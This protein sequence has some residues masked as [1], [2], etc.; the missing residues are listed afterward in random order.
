MVYAHRTPLMNRLQHFSFLSSIGLFCLGGT[1]MAEI[2]FIRDVKPV[3]EFNCVACHR[4]DKAK[5]KLRLDEKAFA[6]KSKDVLTPGD[7]EESALYWM[8]TLPPDD[9]EIMP[10]IEHEDK[11]YPLLKH[12]Q[13]ILK[14]WIKEG[15]K[16]PDGVKLGVHK[17]LP[18]EITFEEHVQPII[19]Q[20]CV[21]CHRKDKAKGKLRL[22]TFEHAFASETNLVPGEPLE[23]DFWVLSSLPPDD[24]DVMPPE[25]NDP[26]SP[27]D[28]YMLRRWIE[29]GA[30]WPE[31]IT[32]KPKKKSLTVIGM[33]PKE[34]YQKLG[35]KAGAV[36]DAFSAYTQ[37][38]TTSDISFDML[39]VKGGTFIM[40]SPA[41]DL[42]RSK[43]EHLAHNV[44]VSDFWMGKYELTWDEY[45]LWMINLDKDNREYKKL[46][47]TQEDKLADGVTK[48]TAPYTDMT[49]GMGKS[50]YP[51]ICMT[52]LSAKMYCMW[53]S[54]RT[55]QFYRLPTEAEWEYACKAGTDTAYSFGDDKSELTK[56]SWHLGNSRFKYQKV[57]QK[58]ANPWGLHD[59]HGNVWEW[60][61]DQYAPP[62]DKAPT[63]LMVNPLVAPN[64]LY[65][66]LVKGGSW[67]DGSTKHR[68]AA[69]LGS[70]LAWKQQDPQLPQSV[71]YHT[72]AIFVGFRLVRPR[73]IPS[74]EEIEQFWPSEE[75][76]RA[77]PSR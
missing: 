32:L 54:A 28:L 15:A 37:E 77:I 38:I 51:A 75:D 63:K 72:D 33:M 44:Q 23:S 69:R 64:T 62:A 35:F 12:E 13:Q 7:P 19:E 70:N 65:P 3:L 27:D 39:P 9:D 43:E 46:E 73:E 31:G 76:I 57:G 5:G 61:L 21:S 42:G 14:Q 74:L 49:F 16:W 52:Q 56:H 50:G 26:L 4:E 2:D 8:T 55:G 17:R 6:F 68:S 67:D 45:E 71:W 24:E 22:D 58:P 40:G 48:P 36:N 34:L 20:N 18:K 25:G 59:M 1:L 60:V 66:R 11:E 53:L 41:D 29:E 47:T 30:E 10:P